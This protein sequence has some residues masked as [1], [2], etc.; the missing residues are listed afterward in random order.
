M[1]MCHCSHKIKELSKINQFLIFICC[2]Y[3]GCRGVIIDMKHCSPLK[4]TRSH[5]F[6][7]FS[8][9]WDNSFNY[10]TTMNKLVELFF[11]NIVNVWNYVFI[12]LIFYVLQFCV[13]SF[14]I[15]YTGSIL[16]SF[17]CDLTLLY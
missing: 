12:Q 5:F 9:C 8:Q 6:Y 17:T 14:T 16:S 1:F 7:I 15:I 13:S 10:P 4:F 2:C 3:I 11:I